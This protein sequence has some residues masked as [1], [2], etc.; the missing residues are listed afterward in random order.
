V[1]FVDAATADVGFDDVARVLGKRFIGLL[2]G[3][4]SAPDEPRQILDVGDSA[5]RVSSGKPSMSICAS[6]LGATGLTMC[7]SNPD[8]NACSRSDDRP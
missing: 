1:R 3:W 4:G 2:E 8:A 7:P 5:G 6:T